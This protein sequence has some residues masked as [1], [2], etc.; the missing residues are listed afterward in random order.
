MRLVVSARGE[1]AIGYRL[2]AQSWSRP[3]FYGVHLNPNKA[4][5]VTLGA[6]DSVIVLAQDE[7]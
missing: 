6:G 4:A 1:T 3:N 7:H 2:A 5:A